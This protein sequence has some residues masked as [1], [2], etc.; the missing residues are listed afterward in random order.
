MRDIMRHASHDAGVREDQRRFALHEPCHVDAGDQPAG[1]AFHIAFH[2]AQLPGK[3]QIVAQDT[4]IGRLQHL[5][6]AKVR[7]AVHHPVTDDAAL[8][9]PGDHRQQALLLSPF[10]MRLE[11]DDIIQRIYG[12][13]LAQLHDRIRTAAIRALQPHRLHRPKQQ[14]LASAARHLLHR[15]ASFEIDLPVDVVHLG[16]FSMDQLVIK[17]VELLLIQRAVDIIR[18]ALVIARLPVCLR[19]VDGVFLDDRRR[20]IIEMEIV[21]MQEGADVLGQRVRGQRS[22]GDDHRSLRDRL[23]FLMDDLHEGMRAQRLRDPG[24]KALAVHGQRTAGRH[25]VQICA[26]HDQGIQHAHLFLEH[27]HRIV[28]GIAAQRI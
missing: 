16:A 9:Q 13:V 5:G 20:R 3:E 7:V 11:A 26:L 1:R 12:I 15:H 17:A 4:L 10:Q 14:R 28:Q 23:H 25:P 8:L 18:I 6:R 21:R 2:P 19:E 22:A 24:R 27:A